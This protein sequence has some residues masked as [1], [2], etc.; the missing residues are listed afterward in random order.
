MSRSMTGFS[1]LVKETK[2]GGFVGEISSLN[3]KFFEVNLNLPKCFFLYEMDLRKKI[4]EKISR[5]QLFLRIFFTPKTAE[6]L[7]FLPE[8]KLLQTLKKGWEE[9]ASLLGLGEKSIDLGFLAEQAKDVPVAPGCIEDDRIKKELFS[10][11]DAL[12]A[13]LVE[14][15]QKEGRHLVIDIQK[16][17]RGIEKRIE[18]I[19][20]L[21]AKSVPRYREKLRKKVEEYFTAQSADEERL[22]KE[23]LLFAE[24]IDITEELVR[25]RSHLVQVDKLLREKKEKEIGRKLEFFVQEFHREVN[26]MGSKTQEALVSQE[27]VE[28]KC[29]LEKIREQVQNIE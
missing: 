10:F 27:V 8:P 21:A 9:R 11:V 14:T 7:S 26:T 13:K 2:E 1:R 3:K 4:G 17:L 16:R 15:K 19:E 6:L 18:K 25:F 29:E 24:R 5:G 22:L 23:V 12:V 20:Q 28:I